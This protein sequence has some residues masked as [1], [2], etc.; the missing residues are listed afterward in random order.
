RSART[1]GG[2]VQFDRVGIFE[3]D[4]GWRESARPADPVLFLSG[5]LEFLVACGRNA[6]GCQNTPKGLVRGG[7]D[8]AP[9]VCIFELDAPPGGGALQNCPVGRQSSVYACVR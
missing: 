5:P 7:M 2:N 4:N 9:G 1:R 8:A 6:E 3:H